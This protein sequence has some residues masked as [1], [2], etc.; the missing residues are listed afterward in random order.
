MN[1]GTR[2]PSPPTLSFSRGQRTALA[3]ALP[4]LL[5]LVLRLRMLHWL[6]FPQGDTLIY[7]GI[8]KNL[9]LHGHYALSG[10]GGL[11]YPTLIRLPGMPFLLALCFRLFGI[12]NYFA[13]ACLQ[14]VLDL[15]GCLL[16]ADFVRRIAPAPQARRA[17]LATLW[18]AALCPFTASFTANPM[19]ETPTLFS[20]ALALWSA[21]GFRQRPRWSLALLFTFAVTLATLLRPDGALVA[22]ALAPALV[23]GLPRDRIAPQKL[24]RMALVCLL[25]ALAPF[26]LWTARNWQVFHVIQPLAPRLATDPGE[27]PNLGW[28]TWIKSWCLDFSSTYEIYWYVPGDQIRID[29]LPARAFDTP[30]QRAATAALIDDYNDQLVLTPALDARF[31]HLAAERLAAHPWRTR[32]GLP[33]GRMANMWLRPRVENLPIEMDWWNYAAHR[34]ETSFSYAWG[35]LNLLY[36]GLAVVGLWKRPPFWR[37]MVLYI[38]LRSALLLT[39]EAPE[40]RYTIECF[41]L[42]F[43]LGGL[44]VKGRDQGRRDQGTRD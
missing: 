28:E 6:Y 8:A 42:L 13:V 44:G 3:V 15:A 36:L 9:L 35:A 34:G 40:T 37:A 5:G 14:I 26:A 39:V 2:P 32:I 4:V 7:G 22:V 17:A 31:A 29:K 21:A 16:L 23:L 20:I 41:P 19:A 24:V 30:A 18:L 43:V 11:P 25:L 12:E 27:D 10:A 33:W 1:A 38:V